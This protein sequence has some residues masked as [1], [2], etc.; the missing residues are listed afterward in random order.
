MAAGW[1]FTSGW[2]KLSRTVKSCALRD[3]C[4]CFPL[5]SITRDTLSAL[6]SSK[7]SAEMLSSTG[8]KR[9]VTLAAREDVLGETSASMSYSCTSMRERLG[10]CA[11]QARA[12]ANITPV[13]AS[14]RNMS[15]LS[16]QNLLYGCS[17]SGLPGG[18]EP[19]AHFRQPVLH[20]GARIL[21]RE[22][23]PGF[24]GDAL[25][26]HL[27]LHQLGRHGAAGNQVHHGIERHAHQQL[28]GR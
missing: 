27:P 13:R 25:A 14:S 18:G 9:T 20:L 5:S 1:P 24:G 8:M 19:G 11:R 3:A 2:S 16:F 23:P 17:H 12:P 21:V 10:G 7:G 15:D 6:L 22:Q 28:A 26:G 4:I